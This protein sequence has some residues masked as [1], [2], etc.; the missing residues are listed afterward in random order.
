MIITTYD[1]LAAHPFLTGLTHQQLTVL[2]AWGSR[3]VFHAGARVF[4]EGG[5]ATRFWLIR[6]G[7]VSL[8][9]HLPG[10]GDVA[11][12]TLG[13]GTVLGWSWL[14]APYRWHFGAV[15]VEDTL[16]VEMDGAGVRRLCDQDPA[17][18]YELT[19]RF[20]AVVVERLQATRVRLLDPYRGPS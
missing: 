9:T 16:T 1:L 17:L 5:R 7:H 4:P 13:P 10:R 14:F 12:E 8:D 6:D 18:G 19:S 11:V 3:S 15:A 20:M 2:S